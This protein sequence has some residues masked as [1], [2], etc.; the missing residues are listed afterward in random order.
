MSATIADRLAQ[1]GV[2]LPAAAAPAANY[3]PWIRFGNLLQTSG[4]LPLADGKIA[5]SGKLGDG[6]SLEEG[7]AAARHCAINILAQAQAA[8]G[9]LETIGRLLKLTVFVASTPDFTEQ[10]K[11]ANGASDFLVEILGDKGRHA[12]SAVGVPALP[13]DAAVEI[14]ALFEIA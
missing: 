3:V 8:L 11:V 5:V 1:A 9:D 6:V 13:L 14:E 12:R 7:Q 10:H 2:E 4:Q